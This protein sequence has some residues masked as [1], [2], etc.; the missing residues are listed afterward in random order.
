MEFAN[1]ARFLLLPKQNSPPSTGPSR[2][3]SLKFNGCL[4]GNHIAYADRKIVVGGVTVVS[5]QIIEIGSVDSA[6]K[7]DGSTD[8]SQVQLTL[9][10]TDGAIKA[11]CDVNDLHK[12]PVWVYQ[13]FRGP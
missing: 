6:A 10:D 3:S 5:G 9:E 8:S 1:A 2:S 7:A 11:L 12:R 4:T 13:W